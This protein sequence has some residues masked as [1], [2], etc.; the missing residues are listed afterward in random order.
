MNASS[1]LLTTW[2]SQSFLKLSECFHGET[3]NTDKSISNGTWTKC[4]KSIY[5]QHNNLDIRVSSTAINIIKNL[6]GD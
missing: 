3:Q 1:S 6:H 4:P 2:V 5:V